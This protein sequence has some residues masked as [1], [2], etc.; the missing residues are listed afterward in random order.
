[1]KPNMTLHSDGIQNQFNFLRS[2][3][4]SMVGCDADVRLSKAVDS[5]RFREWRASLHIVHICALVR[6]LADEDRP[7]RPSREN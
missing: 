4:T 5:W 1:M 3:C 7:T 6:A 2:S